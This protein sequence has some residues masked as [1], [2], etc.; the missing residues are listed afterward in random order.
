MHRLPILKKEGGEAIEQ[1]GRRN[2]G[3]MIQ[4]NPSKKEK[5][6]T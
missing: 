3:K 6:V 2:V 4:L 5:R 1:E